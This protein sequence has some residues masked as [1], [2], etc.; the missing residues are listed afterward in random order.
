MDARK[1]VGLVFRDGGFSAQLLPGSRPGERQRFGVFSPGSSRD[2]ASLNRV[3]GRAECAA[4][5]QT[6]TA[7]ARTQGLPLPFA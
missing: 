5:S 3:G 4:L 7:G 1:S 6:Q 2:V